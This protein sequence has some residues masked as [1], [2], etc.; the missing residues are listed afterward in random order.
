MNHYPKE[1]RLESDIY[2]ENC[3][4]LENVICCFF[5]DAQSKLWVIRCSQIL[6]FDFR[7]E[8]LRLPSYQVQLTRIHVI[9][10]IFYHY[11]SHDNGDYNNFCGL[12]ERLYSNYYHKKLERYGLLICGFSKVILQYK[13]ILDR[14]LYMCFILY[15][16]FILYTLHVWSFI[17]VKHSF[18]IF[19]YLPQSTDASNNKH[20]WQLL[21]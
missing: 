15:I 1:V 19:Q 16:C 3:L 7:W 21:M 20:F 8:Y 9:T 14:I 2:K 10:K 6:G 18:R 13:C 4:L 5:N 11:L 17:S 12:L